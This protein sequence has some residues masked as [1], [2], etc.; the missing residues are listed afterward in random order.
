MASPVDDPVLAA[1][2]IPGTL[3]AF[4]KAAPG[5]SV[6]EAALAKLHAMQ[7][8]PS[9]TV[10]A[11]AIA[12]GETVPLL[13]ALIATPSVNPEQVDDPVTDPFCN[14]ERMAQAL[15]A[16]FERL[17]AD[18]VV[19]DAEETQPGRPNVYAVFRCAQ[20]LPSARWLGIDVHIDTVAVKGMAPYGPFDAVL[21]DEDD[22]D[23]NQSVGE[24]GRRK[25][26]VKLHGRGACDTKATLAN[27]MALLGEGARPAL[28]H[29]LVLCGTVG[30]ETGRLGAAA[31]DAW[32][33]RKGICVDEMLVAEPTMCEPIYGHKGHVRLRFDLKGEPA[34]S[35]LPHLGKNAIA[36][37]AAL[38]TALFEEGERLRQLPPPQPSTSHSHP[39]CYLGPPT[40]TPTLI[41]GGSGIN[42]V[43]G[44]ASVSVDRRV[45]AG[46]SADN[47]RAGLEVL[48][49]RVC[50]AHQQCVSMTVHGAQQ[51]PVGEAFVQ[52]GG[53]PFVRRLVRWGGGEAR[54]A[55]YGTNAGLPY[56]GDVTKAVAVFG[57][58]DIAQ[59]HQADEWIE[60]SQL[61]LHKRVLREWLCGN[62]ADSELESCL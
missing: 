57:P 30:E 16:R 39:H 54:T 33:R 2:G 56:G 24:G 62:W 44:A 17:G 58:G 45:V 59:A 43:P 5:G 38:T 12:L 14:E 31:L 61:A 4:E 49:R 50:D 46:E 60:L 10:R 23:G 9:A 29:H 13:R 19:V 7:P 21:T 35:S 48:A 53:S 32:L 55:T 3:M 20:P 28:R 34:H 6:R 8:Y 15:A 52:N 25:G 18:E 27:V 22:C 42:I 40:L 36:A 1:A 47:V 26:R 37:A 11:E 41:K 51:A